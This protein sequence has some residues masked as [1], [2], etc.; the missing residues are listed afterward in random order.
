MSLAGEKL[1]SA[2]LGN[3]SA[4]MCQA[5]N[6][7]K[8]LHSRIRKAPASNQQLAYFNFKKMDLVR[9]SKALV[10]LIHPNRIEA[11]IQLKQTRN[12]ASFLN[13]S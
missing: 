12:K 2:A 10:S 5:V 8:T 13:V 1:L 4:S 11:N 6:S 3:D 9:S 7:D